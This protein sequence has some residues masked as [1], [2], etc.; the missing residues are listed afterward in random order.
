MVYSE[1]RK[2]RELISCFFY[3][4][5]FVSNCWMDSLCNFIGDS[6]TEQVS[7]VLKYIFEIKKIK[8]IV[9][10]RHIEIVLRILISIPFT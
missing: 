5:I 3:P 8:R 4:T 2:A 1:Y 10:N 7:S 6:L 9:E